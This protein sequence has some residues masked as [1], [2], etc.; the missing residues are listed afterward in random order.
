[1]AGT[2]FY[3]TSQNIYLPKDSLTWTDLGNSPY[4]TWDN[5]TSWYQ[6]IASDTTVAFTSAIID[7]GRNAKVIPT[8]TIVTGKDGNTSEAITLDSSNENIPTIL[9]EGSVNSDMS[10]AS[11]VTLTRTSA[12]TY[13]SLGA[14]RYY[15]VT[16]TLNAGTNSAPQ[17]LT[18][19]NIELN[20]NTSEEILEGIDTSDYDDGSSATRT[21]TTNNTYTD[22]QYVGITPT[23]T[24]SDTVVTGTGSVSLYVASSYVTTGYF[25]G[26]TSSV[27]TSSITSVPLARC[28]SKSTNNFTVQIYLPNNATETDG[29]FDFMV[30]G[31][32]Q[33][34]IDATTGN[35]GSV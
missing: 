9:V 2:G 18:G 12:P 21:I 35:L 26:D 3:D 5:Y 20:T 28:V 14:K 1:M 17:G 19:L 22:I 16:V 8:V 13:T 25:V 15:R 10:S 23:S 32:P 33:S 27:T 30:R 11:T 4:Q 31:L 24:V 34:K 7:F 29:V 6:N